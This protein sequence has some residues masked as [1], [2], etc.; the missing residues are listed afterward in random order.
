[1]Y[2]KHFS[3]KYKPF[4]LVPNPDFL[5]LSGT[6]KRAITCLDYGI[7]EK[8]G[9]ILLT[10]E[11]GSGKTTII[12]NFIKNLNR[13]VKLSRV[14][15]TKVSAELL[16][17]M[18]NEDF[19]IDV[20]GKTKNKLL[21]DLNEFLIEQYA[22]KIQP[23]LLIDEAQNLTPSMLEEIRL[24]SNLETNTAK[25][26]QII[27]VGQPELAKTLMLPELS[28]LRQRIQIKYHISPMTIEETSQYVKHR[29]RIAGNP[30]AINV[31][32]D[33]IRYIYKFSKG[34]PRL[35]NIICD[36]A[37]LIA[38]SEKI[39]QVSTEI[40]RE[41]SNDLE[42]S[43]YLS[44]P[45]SANVPF[46]E[47]SDADSGN[48]KAFGDFESRLNQLEE[49]VKGL[50]EKFS[51]VNKFGAEQK[52]SLLV[53]HFEEQLICRTLKKYTEEN[54]IKELFGRVSELEKMSVLIDTEKMEYHL[55]TKIEE[56]FRKDSHPI[57]KERVDE[58]VRKIICDLN[59]TMRD[60]KK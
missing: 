18:I 58:M 44:I 10:G 11:I 59:E 50:M 20:E 36:F 14:N 56:C 32:E 39:A 16:L 51:T 25:L 29:L 48:V 15:N 2:E 31:N 42:S 3:L 23:A 47:S 35:I 9:F 53:E 46:S 30:H 38:F 22:K 8:I 1:M 27:L 34:I 26:I 13:S 21:S 17:S 60:L 12:S 43:N 55:G 52:Y 19:G 54:K 7:R 4:E 41:V 33:T 6:H 28:Q 45:H 40:I 37:L 5:F 57:S 24:L 49:R